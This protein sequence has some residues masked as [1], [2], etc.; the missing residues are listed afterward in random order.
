[1]TIRLANWV[2][3]AIVFMNYLDS[4]LRA[5]I[6][7][8]V[9][10]K[11]KEIRVDEKLGDFLPLELVFIDERGQ[12]TPLASLC[13]GKRPLLLTLNYSNCPGLCV[14]QLN[15]LT[16]GVAELSGLQLGKDF[17]MVSISIDPRETPEKAA[18]MKQRYASLLPK[19]HDA[20]GW[21]FLTGDA[22]SIE[23]VAD[24][25]GF[26]YTYD[27]KE[28]RFNHASVAIGISPSGKITRYLYSIGFAPET[29]RLSLVE[30]SE[31][32]IGTTADQILLWCFHYNPDEN[33]YS[34]DARR[35]LSFAAGAFVLI[36]L[37]ASA[38][39]W[40]SRQKALANNT[41][42]DN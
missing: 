23:R 29:I 1:M 27:K 3:L 12:P 15:G 8:D 22:K 24:A 37:G 30:A 11:A 16:E 28:D 14:A 34:A 41:P 31:G 17:D 33:R 32:R 9:P 19:E 18:S 21:H 5:Q 38:P 2:L 4:P 36:G 40:F 7:T 13:T 42:D 26:R 20:K 6:L 25:V 10:E 35:L 39:F